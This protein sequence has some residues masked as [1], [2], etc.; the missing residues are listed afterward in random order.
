MRALIVEDEVHLARTLKDMLKTV[1][2]DSDI[3]FDGEAGLDYGLS[4][5]YDLIVLDIMLP[6]RDG[7]EVANRLRKEHIDTPILMLTARTDI[8]DRVKGLDCGA[9]YYLTKPFE[10]NELLACVR[11]L[12]RRQGE[13]VMDALTLGDLSLNLSTCNLCCGER[14]VRLGKKEFSIM[15]ILFSAGKSV[16]SKE[17][18]L[19]KVWGCDSDAEDN[20][21]EVYISFLRK[22]LQYLKT[23]VRI[24]TL[25]KFGYKL[26]EAEE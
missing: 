17:T 5:V 10:M 6:M 25:R 8:E 11:A 21:V 18:L 19:N 22:K 16:V 20:N 15:H 13:V 9:D 3:C 12:T 23:T 26:E 14:S 2:F 7:F 1:H 4:N 24:V